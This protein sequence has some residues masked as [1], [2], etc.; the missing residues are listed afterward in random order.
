MVGGRIIVSRE[1]MRSFWGH[2]D[3]TA[4]QVF[5]APGGLAEP[6]MAQINGFIPETSLVRVVSG[7]AIK[8]SILAVFD[9]TFLITSALQVLTAIVALTGILNSF[10]ALLLERTREMGILRACGAERHQVFWL[11]MWECG[12]CGVLSGMMALPLGAWL[13]WI[14]VHV[15]NLRSFGWTYEM[16]VTPWIFVEALFLA[17]GAALAAGVFPGLSAGRTDIGQALHME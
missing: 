4:L 5:L 14:L 16:V 15:I 7:G 1:G 9:R 10:M 12:I 17:S 8:H 3:V 13:A 6:L 2:A 11:M